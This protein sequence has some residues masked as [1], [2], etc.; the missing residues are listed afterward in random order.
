VNTNLL[1]IDITN[2]AERFT[3]LKMQYRYSMH[4]AREGKPNL[5]HSL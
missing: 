3:E 5:L 2:M 4:V 1:E